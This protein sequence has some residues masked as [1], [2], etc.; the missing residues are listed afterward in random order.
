[1]SNP[2][3]ANAAIRESDYDMM[4]FIFKYAPNVEINVAECTSLSFFTF[5]MSQFG[6]HLINR[7]S[8]SG[9]V[10]Q[11]LHTIG[12]ND[13]FN[14][15][16]IEDKNF[17]FSLVDAHK[18]N[19]LH[20]VPISWFEQVLQSDFAITLLT[21]A[22]S[23]GI[24]PIERFLSEPC[25]LA[26][27]AMINDK[28]PEIWNQRVG[29]NDTVASAFINLQR[30]RW[31]F[32]DPSKLIIFPNV[33][34]VFHAIID[35]MNV[36]WD[37][38][39]KYATL[40]SVN[41]SVI[42]DGL[43]LNALPC[44]LKHS[45]PLE[46]YEYLYK[47]GARFPKGYCVI[48]YTRSSSLLK[49]YFQVCSLPV[50][51][52]SALKGTFQKKFVA[53]ADTTDVENSWTDA[54]VNS[55]FIVTRVEEGNYLAVLYILEKCTT[56]KHLLQE[57]FEQNVKFACGGTIL[58]VLAQEQDKRLKLVEIATSLSKFINLTPLLEMKNNDNKT[59]SEVEHIKKE[60]KQYFIKLKKIKV[61]ESPKRPLQQLSESQDEDRYQLR[62]R[63]RK[64]K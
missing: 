17:D 53:M 25:T 59:C 57:H 1:M 26:A 63:Q 44:L 56:N 8:S 49:Y 60:L 12:F 16:S 36:N 45:I 40:E 30:D 24:K 13:L 54:L 37:I 20:F 52:S 47:L 55:S 9:E 18:N 7:K 46:H 48:D 50:L 4:A 21:E 22:N 23:D 10:V 39:L 14:L 43:P 51:K 11:L 6:N 15:K 35:K 38:L 32:V 27:L 28:I 61:E 64:F 31:N 19:I 2:E 29:V 42:I 62:K 34:T 41:H 58:H 33:K 3:I 5:L